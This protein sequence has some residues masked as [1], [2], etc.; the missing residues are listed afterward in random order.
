[1]ARAGAEFGLARKTASYRLGKNQVK[2]Y[3]SI[4]SSGPFEKGIRGDQKRRFDNRG[5]RFECFKK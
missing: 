2:R 4:E 3:F 1:V 5:R